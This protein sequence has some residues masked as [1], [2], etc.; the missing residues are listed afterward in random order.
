MSSYR[1]PVLPALPTVPV[2][3]ILLCFISIY[4]KGWTIPYTS[5]VLYINTKTLQ[6]WVNGSNQ[7]VIR[8]ITQK[9]FRDFNSITAESVGRL[10]S[11]TEKKRIIE[12][13]TDHVMSMRKVLN[14][15]EA[16]FTKR[17]LMRHNFL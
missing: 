16:I 5:K 2:E 11:P 10:I 8:V 17:T 14:E 13:A 4:V 12:T 3:V 7:R 1:K 9:G 6:N 15:R